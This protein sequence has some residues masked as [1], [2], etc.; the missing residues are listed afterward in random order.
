MYFLCLTGYSQAQSKTD[1]ASFRS[2]PM[3]L[4]QPAD[5]NV[6][7]VING[8]MLGPAHSVLGKIDNAFHPESLRR[9]Q[10]L[11]GEKAIQKY[12]EAARHGVLEIELKPVAFDE[13]KIHEK[14]KNPHLPVA[15][16]KI[17]NGQTARNPVFP[18]GKKTS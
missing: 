17:Q 8:K 16:M 3:A 9:V 2:S 13:V 5:S 4:L 6:L 15:L 7:I 1:S 18:A 12:G 14:L 11:K 10:L